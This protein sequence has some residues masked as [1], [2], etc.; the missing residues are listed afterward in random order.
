M[1][2]EINGIKQ[3]GLNIFVKSFNSTC[4]TYEYL[5]WASKQCAANISYLLTLAQNNK[6][7]LCLNN[8][9][10]KIQAKDITI[11]VRNRNEANIIKKNIKSLQYSF[12]L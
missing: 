3:S 9:I 10:R 6:A 7:I 5:Q 12:F 2:F 1:Y 8:S 11:L 4:Y